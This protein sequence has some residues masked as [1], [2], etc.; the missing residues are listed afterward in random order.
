MLIYC[1]SLKLICMIHTSFR[2]YR[3]GILLLDLFTNW[4]TNLQYLFPFSPYGKK[5]DENKNKSF[6][7]HYGVNERSQKISRRVHCRDYPNIY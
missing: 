7:Y 2:L 3:Y 5:R 4:Q 6:L 1:Q